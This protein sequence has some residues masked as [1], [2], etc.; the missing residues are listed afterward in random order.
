VR[1]FR[2]FD[3]PFAL[4]LGVIDVKTH[5]VETPALVAARI[6]AALELVP[7]DRLAVNPDC[8]CLHLPRDVAFAK[9]CAMVEGARA[10]R[11]ELSG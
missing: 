9:L 11:R 8:G 6:R 1:L 5:D 3:S 4:G 2:E 7:A 10:V